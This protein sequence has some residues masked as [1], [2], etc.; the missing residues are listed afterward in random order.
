MDAPIVGRRTVLGSGV[1]GLV[2]LAGCLDNPFGSSGPRERT[3]EITVSRSGEALAVSIEPSSDVEDV[4]QVNVGDTVTFDIVNDAGAPVGIHNHATDE[5]IVV[6]AGGERTTEFEATE[7]MTGRHEIE[8]WIAE[9]DS[10]TAE[11]EHGED[12]TALAVLE[13]RPRGS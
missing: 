6:E 9:D 12:A 5:E 4:V 8:G 2:A 13:V 3:Y 1:A 7:S 10:G 11:G